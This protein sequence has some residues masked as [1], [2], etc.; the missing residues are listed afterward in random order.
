MLRLLRNALSRF[1]ADVFELINDRDIIRKVGNIEVYLELSSDFFFLRA[2]MKFFDLLEDAFLLT[3]LPRVYQT[4]IRIAIKV[5]YGNCF[6]AFLHIFLEWR[7]LETYT[8][9]G[10]FRMY[11]SCAIIDR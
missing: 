3:M 5:S 9:K 1:D 4:S 10:G 11:L 6:R 2:V 8:N 7:A